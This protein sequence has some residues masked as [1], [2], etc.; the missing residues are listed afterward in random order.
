[1]ED[2]DNHTAQNIPSDR[3]VLTSSQIESSTNQPTNQEPTDQLV[4]DKKSGRLTNSEKKYLRYQK[5]LAN[6][7]LKRE[8][9]KRQKRLLKRESEKSAAGQ[10]DEFS[11]EK[12]QRENDYANVNTLD[13]ENRINA[14]KKS[15]Q[16][17]DLNMRLNVHK[18][19]SK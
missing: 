8:E 16:S 10:D 17:N 11:N 3:L 9:K 15:L 13:T 5:K 19:V 14:S 1:M 12:K 2:S 4:S 7:K 6:Y 18:I